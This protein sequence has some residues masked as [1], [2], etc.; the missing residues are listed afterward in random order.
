VIAMSDCSLIIQTSASVVLAIVT[1]VYVCLTHRILTADKEAVDLARESLEDQRKQQAQNV[2]V[3]LYPIRA[4]VLEEMESGHL[5]SAITQAKIL[6]GE[7]VKQLVSSLERA[8]EERRLA[9]RRVDYCI[10]CIKEVDPIAHSQYERLKTM[11]ALVRPEN[12]ARMND[13]I[14]GILGKVDFVIPIEDDSRHREASY[15]TLKSNLSDKQLQASMAKE[16]VVDAMRE[17]ITTSLGM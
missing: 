3:Q 7:P 1:C 14:D 16:A 11:Q 13:E 6:F 2:G 17:E 5:H 4:A 8:E 10:S 15:L 12:Y 9:Q